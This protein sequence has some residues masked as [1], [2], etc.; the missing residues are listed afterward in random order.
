[1]TTEIQVTEH[2]ARMA[3][4]HSEITDEVYG[5]AASARFLTR[6]RVALLIVA[7]LALAALPFL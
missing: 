6:D 7:A 5:Q 4:M 3:E 2:D 1:M